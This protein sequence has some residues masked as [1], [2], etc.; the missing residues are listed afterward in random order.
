VVIRAV[1]KPVR[2]KTI[3][4]SS[5]PSTHHSSV[6][7]PFSRAISLGREASEH[8]KDRR[9]RKTADG[10]REHL[11]YLSEPSQGQIEMTCMRWSCH[12]S[13]WCTHE[14]R[15]AHHHIQHAIPRLDLSALAQEKCEKN[16]SPMY[17]SRKNCSKPSS[18]ILTGC[19]KIFSLHSCILCHKRFSLPSE[20][21]F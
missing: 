1:N 17:D 21:Y 11:Q 6:S 18:V 13:H 3:R 7:L 4:T 14:E 2:L 12:G 10:A 8:A 9:G 19:R 15:T 5:G 16:V 20:C